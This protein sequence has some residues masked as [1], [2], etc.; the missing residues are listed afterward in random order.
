MKLFN[1][2]M[3]LYSCTLEQYV[4]PSSAWMQNS[5]KFQK[6]SKSTMIFN[7]FYF[8]ER[9]F[10]NSAVEIKKALLDFLWK[11]MF[12]AYPLKLSKDYWLVQSVLSRLICFSTNFEFLFF[13]VYYILFYCF[14]LFFIKKVLVTSWMAKILFPE[15]IDPV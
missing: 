15:T 6:R 2:R 9:L 14:L 11:L 7:S 5:P 4:G 3:P 10:F 13:P 8:Q 1:D 12:K